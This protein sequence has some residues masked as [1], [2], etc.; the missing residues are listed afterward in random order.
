[1]RKNE[2]KKI[3]SFKSLDDRQSE[4]SSKFTKETKCSAYLLSKPAETYA[5]IGEQV[6]TSARCLQPFAICIVWQPITSV[7]IITVQLE[8]IGP[9]NFYFSTRKKKENP[10][11]GLCGDYRVKMIF[12]ISLPVQLLLEKCHSSSTKIQGSSNIFSVWTCKSCKSSSDNDNFT[13]KENTL[14]DTIYTEDLFWEPFS[15]SRI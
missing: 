11:C 15:P 1:M 10:F 9:R 2:L 4:Y 8:D 5:A 13:K 7:K 3:S 14:T 12:L 6:G